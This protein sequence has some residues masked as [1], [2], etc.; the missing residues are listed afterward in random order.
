LPAIDCY[1]SRW[2]A[3][4]AGCPIATVE[5]PRQNR[6]LRP[7]NGHLLSGYP[8]TS[9][10]GRMCLA[11]AWCR[12][13]GPTAVADR[14]K[15]VRPADR[16]QHRLCSP[17]SGFFDVDEW[18]G[19]RSARPVHQADL[20]PQPACGDTR[21]AAHPAPRWFEPLARLSGGPAQMS[22]WSAIGSA[23]VQ[24]VVRD[25][26]R[27]FPGFLRRSAPGPRWSAQKQRYAREE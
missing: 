1:T 3:R 17:G 16:G 11:G 2:S 23:M 6:R 26:P 15:P 5:L 27:H 4:D 8:E 25:A 19:E 24:R 21:L 20:G 9:G 14:R 18:E 22:P 10:R 13:W 7:S 12:S